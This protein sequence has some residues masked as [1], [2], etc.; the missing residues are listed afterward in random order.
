[1]DI[2]RHKWRNFYY[3]IL[4]LMFVYLV[5]TF[6][7]AARHTQNAIKILNLNLLLGWTL[8][9]WVVALF[10]SL[11]RDAAIVTESVP[12][13]ANEWPLVD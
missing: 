10:W 4:V 11:S 9:G 6:I 3:N 13:D 12:A 8:P 5:P 2:S 7:A 1:L